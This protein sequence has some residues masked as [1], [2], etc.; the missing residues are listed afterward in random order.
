MWKSLLRLGGFGVSK[1]DIEKHKKAIM[2]LAG[3]LSALAWRVSTPEERNAGIAIQK[4]IA[5]ILEVE[6]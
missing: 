3:Y 2:R 6:S 4:E 5:E 1:E